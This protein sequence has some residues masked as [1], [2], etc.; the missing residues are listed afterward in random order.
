LANTV[1]SEIGDETRWV[2]ERAPSDVL[3]WAAFRFSSRVTFATGFG[4]EGCVLIDLIAR[5]CLPIDI[6]TLDTGLL[7]PETYALWKRLESRYGVTIRAVRPEES[8]ER[9]AAVHGDRMW[10]RA[11]D[12][13]CALRKLAPLRGALQ[14]FDAWITAIRRDQTADRAQ[15]R[16]VESD[17]N[18]GIV[19]INPLASWTTDDVW[20]YIKAHDVP[21]NAL[22]ARGYPSI[23]CWPCTSAVRPGESAR[24][25][26][27]RSL[28]K[29]ECGLHTRAANPPVVLQ[30]QR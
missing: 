22:H 11:P 20:A 4:V 19:K 2:E 23:G 9:Q 10:E 8:V 7:F 26:R 13:C 27:W 25:G 30:L 21:V 1:E 29:T 18:F 15:I 6:F 24:A 17:P 14:G 28:E 12:R 3:L 16:V 5:Q